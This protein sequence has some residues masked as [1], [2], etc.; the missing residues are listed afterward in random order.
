MRPIVNG[1][2]RKFVLCDPQP[3]LPNG[4][5]PREGQTRAPWGTVSRLAAG[6]PVLLMRGSPNEEVTE[7]VTEEV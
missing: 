6:I 7:P 4:K 3:Y 5:V 2:L 1:E